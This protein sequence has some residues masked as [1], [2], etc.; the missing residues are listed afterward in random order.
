[1]GYGD[2]LMLTAEARRLAEQ[3]GKPAIVGNNEWSPMWENNPYISKTGDGP[4]TSSSIGRRPYL[5]AWDNERLYYNEDFRPE[6]GEIYFSA[7]ENSYRDSL[8]NGLVM[9]EP[10]VK[11]TFGGNKAWVWDRWVEVAKALPVTQCLQPRK[12]PLP[13]ATTIRTD[14][15]RQAL[16]VLS[17]AKLLITTDGALHHAAAALGVPAIVI[18]GE[19]T[20]PLILGY[21]EHVNLMSGDQFCGMMAPCSHCVKAMKAIAVDQVIDAAERI[22]D[23]GAMESN[24]PVLC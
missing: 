3:H 10:H 4:R 13:G 22:L 15:I 5:R 23:R 9:V 17:K 19:R 2:D 11:G 1:M 12:R 16:C 21:P 14:S 6:R 20:N 18:W 24:S 7:E 8:P